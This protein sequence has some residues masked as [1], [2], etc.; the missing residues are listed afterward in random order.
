M[1]WGHFGSIPS[2]D[3]LAGSTPGMPDMWQVG[4]HVPCIVSQRGY[5][6]FIVKKS[7]NRTRCLGLRGTVNGK[8]TFPAAVEGGGLQ[9]REDFGRLVVRVLLSSFVP[10]A[11]IMFYSMM[12]TLDVSAAG[13]SESQQKAYDAFVRYGVSPPSMRQRDADNA[14]DRAV[15]LARK[16]QETE[17]Y[18]IS[19]ALDLLKQAEENQKQ[20]KYADA[21]E[22][23]QLVIDGYPDLALAE[24][25]RMKRALMEYQLGKIRD[26]ILHLEDEEVAVRGNAEVHAAL[27]AVLYAERPNELNIAEEQWDIATEFDTRYSSIEFVENNRY[28]P[29]A[30]VSA[31]KKF[32]L[33]QRS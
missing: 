3:G 27:A 8:E 9:N 29:P 24:R 4:R 18:R 31:L 2:I 30:M 13:F 15:G 12:N 7:V 23:Y 25:A 17:K 20:G 19:T 11:L 10:S 6:R 1:V 21:L 28:W 16:Q 32:L 14:A 5:F 26:S 22:G 33:L